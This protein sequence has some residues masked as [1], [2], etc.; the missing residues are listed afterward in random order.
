MS[1]RCC[2]LEMK[3][4]LLHK[5]SGFRAVQRNLKF[6][7]SSSGDSRLKKL[8]RMLVKS[9]IKCEFLVSDAHSLVL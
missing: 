7:C 8:A 2:D 6:T 5:T 3:N 1:T 9:Y 4:V